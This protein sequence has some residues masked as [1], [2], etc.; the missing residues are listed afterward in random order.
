MT[1]QAWDRRLPAALRD[2]VRVPQR[3]ESHE[4]ASARS[5]KLIGFDANGER[6]FYRHAFIVTELRFDVD[7]WPL[8]LP[9]YWEQVDAWRLA[10]GRWLR[11]DW[12][13]EEDDCRGTRQDRSASL[14][15]HAPA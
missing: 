8:E 13:G 7:E 15:T 10:D 3:F 9:I 1:E 14:S 6:C 11:L 5:R 2:S 4:D 12:H